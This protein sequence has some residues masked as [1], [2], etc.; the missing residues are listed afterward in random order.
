M[1]RKFKKKYL[2]PKRWEAQEYEKARDT[3][4]R[5]SKE[6]IEAIKEK[7]LEKHKKHRQRQMKEV[8]K[9]EGYIEA[10]EWVCLDKK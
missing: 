2:L 5:S 7:Q 8:Q 4:V 10:L 9:L 1:F 6:V 3:D